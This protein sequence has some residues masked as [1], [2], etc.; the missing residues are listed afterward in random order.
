MFLVSIS[1]NLRF[2]N[3][4]LQIPNLFACF[5]VVDQELSSGVTNQKCVVKF[6]DVKMDGNP[7]HRVGP[8]VGT[9]GVMT[10]L[11]FAESALL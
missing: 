6:N 1:Q 4:N 11:I 10:V 9:H 2:V 3:C 5:I 8:D 7:S